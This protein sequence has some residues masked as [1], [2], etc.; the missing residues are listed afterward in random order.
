MFGVKSVLPL[1]GL[2]KV[3]VE[4]RVESYPM[5]LPVPNDVVKFSAYPVYLYVALEISPVCRIVKFHLLVSYLL[6]LEL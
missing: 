2:D 1:R 4:G 6:K 3:G 5:V